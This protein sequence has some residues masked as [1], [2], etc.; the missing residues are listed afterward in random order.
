MRDNEKIKVL[1]VDD[2][3]FISEQLNIIL[4][5][6]GYHVTDIAFN[7]ESAINALKVNTPDIV[8]TDINMHGRNQGFEIAKYINNH[9]SIPFIFL[10]SFADPSTV[11]EASQL[12][13]NAYL[14]KPFNEGNIF[15]TLNI[16]LDR[17]HKKHN[18]FCIKIGHQ[19]HK[20]KEDDLLFIMSS[21]KYIEIHTTTKKYL[22][23]GTIDHFIQENALKGVNRVHRSYAVKLDNIDSVKGSIIYIQDREIPISNT[24]KAEFKKAYSSF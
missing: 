8:I 14:L 18:Y 3:V 12:T 24:Y 20:V 16:V 1:I 7:A 17:Y 22:K 11:K 6:L 19:I 2:D 23:R 5:D 4:E 10:T 15:S 21:D 9:L 13:P